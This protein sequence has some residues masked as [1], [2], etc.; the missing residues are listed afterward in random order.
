MLRRLKRGISYTLYIYNNKNK[1]GDSKKIEQ[2]T[3]HNHNAR[4]TIK[5]AVTVA[6][7]VA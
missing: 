2:N 5:V 1:K 6:V 7:A 3:K 4:Y